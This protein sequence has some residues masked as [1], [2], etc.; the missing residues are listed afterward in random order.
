MTVISLQIAL[1]HTYL[2]H[3]ILKVDFKRNQRKSPQVN[4][5]VSMPKYKNKEVYQEMTQ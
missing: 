1:S 5:V 3:V 4:P 2:S